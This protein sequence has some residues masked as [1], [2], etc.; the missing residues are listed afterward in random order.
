M[1][2]RLRCSFDIVRTESTPAKLVIRDLQHGM[3]VTNDAD[4]VVKFLLKN[5]FIHS[6]R[7]LFYYDTEHNLDE[8][9]FDKDGF[10]GFRHRRSQV[11]A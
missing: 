3:S 9:A 4:A 7:R 11:C 1:E 8:L 10:L 6:G 5:N 2:V